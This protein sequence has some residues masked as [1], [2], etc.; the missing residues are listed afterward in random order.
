MG[1][2]GTKVVD[3]TKSKAIPAS[4][5]NENKLK[6]KP[7]MTIDFTNLTLEHT[8]GKL[9]LHDFRQGIIGRNCLYKTPFGEQL[10]LYAD[11]TASGRPH[12]LVENYI[13]AIL[14]LYANTHSYNSFFAVS[15]NAIYDKSIKYLLEY[16]NGENDYVVIAAGNGA[17]GATYR[18]IDIVNRKFP[19]LMTTNI[20]EIQNIN[21][22]N[23]IG[24]KA[25][26][27]MKN[28]YPIVIVTEYE[29]HSNIISWVYR[30]FQVV[31]I[32][33]SAIHDWEAGLKD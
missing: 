17:T 26:I 3:E 13:K 6:Y 31:P 14:P 33:G 10:S 23:V 16:F 30:G 11:D 27:S 12:K 15:T 25:Q 9:S 7:R 32:L 20:N 18:F 21:D 28:E 24:A 22:G 2:S 8:Q 19:G 29:H 5:K 1:C 4:N